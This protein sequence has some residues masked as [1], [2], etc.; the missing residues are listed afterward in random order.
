[1]SCSLVGIVG[2]VKDIGEGDGEKRVE[3]EKVDKQEGQREKL[4]GKEIDLEEGNEK[5]S[6][7]EEEEAGEVGFERRA[8][9]VVGSYG[10]EGKGNTS[11]ERN[12]FINLASCFCDSTSEG[13]YN[14]F[15]Q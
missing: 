4:G 6:V 2:G 13:A 11:V 12:I 5:R 15:N 3:R 9:L 14:K 10:E 7:V 1:M 8:R